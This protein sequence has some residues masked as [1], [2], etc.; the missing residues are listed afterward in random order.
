MLTIQ[1]DCLCLLMH[2]LQQADQPNNGHYHPTLPQ[3]LL[4]RLPGRQCRNVKQFIDRCGGGLFCWHGCCHYGGGEAVA[5]ATTGLL[6]GREM[7]CKQHSGR[8]PSLTGQTPDPAHLTCG[9]VALK[10]CQSS[11][12]SRQACGDLWHT[13]FSL[14]LLK[15]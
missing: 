9:I 12:K 3:L 4:D 14:G 1:P 10:T 11:K 6:I 15:K 7:G 5:V 8:G 13:Y 2:F